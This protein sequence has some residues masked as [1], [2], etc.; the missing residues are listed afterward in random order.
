MT[1]YMHRLLE[2]SEFPREPTPAL[3]IIST[4]ELIVEHYVVIDQDTSPHVQVYR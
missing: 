4:L 3:Y 2:D 1:E